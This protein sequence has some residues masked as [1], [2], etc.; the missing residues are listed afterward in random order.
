MLALVAGLVVLLALGSLVAVLAVQQRQGDAAAA[1]S[2]R[3]VDTASQTMVNMFTFTQQNLDESVKRFVDGTS[4]PLHDKLS[5]GDN[6][7]NLAAF[8]RATGADSEA[9]VNGAA[10]EGV[11][12]VRDNAS[13]LVA[14]R[15]TPSDAEGNNQPSTPY[16][17][18][19]IVHEDSDEHMSVYDLMYPNGGN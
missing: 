8:L 10:L 6:V 11:D 3:F 19:V 5:Q 9:V 2:Q 13:V 17:L 1:R 7:A 18:R 4:G 16:R 12:E 15:V 14:I